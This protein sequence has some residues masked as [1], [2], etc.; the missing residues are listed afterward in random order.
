[1]T[2]KELE[3]I[4]PLKREIKYLEQKVRARC[5]SDTVKGSGADF[6]YCQHTIGIRGVDED[7]QAELDQLQRKK[8]MLKTYINFI[9][10]VEDVNTR[11]ILKVRYVDG[12]KP[13]R[14]VAAKVGGNNTEDG[15]KQ[16]VSRFFRKVVT[17]CH[18]FRDII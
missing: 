5:V 11:L 1:M 6:P 8:I 10:G 14:E 4:I 17:N 12:V 2:R 13:W 3:D 15:V 16:V 18:D 9:E 7:G